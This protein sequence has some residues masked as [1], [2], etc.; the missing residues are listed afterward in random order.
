[1]SVTLIVRCVQLDHTSQQTLTLHLIAAAVGLLLLP[2]FWTPTAAL[3]VT[4]TELFIAVSRYGD[5]WASILLASLGVA[6]ALLGPGAWSVDAQR[7]GLKRI[8]IRRSDE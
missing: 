5:P 2:G 8:E 1:V 7:F 3:A 4:I 6:V